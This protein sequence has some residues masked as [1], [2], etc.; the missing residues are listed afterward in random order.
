MYSVSGVLNIPYAEINEPF[1]AWYDKANG[2]SRID[3]YGG[4]VKTY[5][6]TKQGSYGVSLKLAPVTTQ[7]Q[8]NKETCLQV[9]GSADNAIAVQG[10]LPYA[11]DF[12]LIGKTLWSLPSFTPT[13][14]A[15]LGAKNE[16]RFRGLC[17]LSVRPVYADRE[18]WPEAQ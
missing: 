12:K 1:Y 10:I 13:Y 11:K 17:R 2:R 16:N 3:Y 9:N 6:L 8:T 5:Q 7:S 14:H 15:L 4:M 18:H